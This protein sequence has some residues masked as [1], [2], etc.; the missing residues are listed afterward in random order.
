MTTRI[1]IL[2]FAAITAL[3]PARAE[4]IQADLSIFGMD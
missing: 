1:L 2:T 3:S 4:L